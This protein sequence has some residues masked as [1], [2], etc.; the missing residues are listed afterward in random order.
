VGPADGI[1]AIYELFEV[2]EEVSGAWEPA[3]VRG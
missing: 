3:G 2:L 1:P